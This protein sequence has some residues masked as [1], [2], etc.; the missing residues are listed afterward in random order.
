MNGI[1]D[2]LNERKQR[3]KLLICKP[4]QSIITKLYLPLLNYIQEIETYMKC[5]PG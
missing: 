4:D 1:N 2:L 5:K 3:E